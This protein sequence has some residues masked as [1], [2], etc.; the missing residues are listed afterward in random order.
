MR[1]R[2]KK[3]EPSEILRRQLAWNAQRVAATVVRLDQ[4]KDAMEMRVR[5]T[6]VVGI[7]SVVM[8]TG[9][10]SVPRTLKRTRVRKIK[11]V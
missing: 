8:P 5:H 7:P 9:M 3:Q 11:I 4:L 2:L 10:E 6:S 1:C